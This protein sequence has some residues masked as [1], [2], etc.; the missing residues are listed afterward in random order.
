M[1]KKVLF[2]LGALAV[3]AALVLTHQATA[4]YSTATDAQSTLVDEDVACAEF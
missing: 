3:L 2:G 1:K 4:A